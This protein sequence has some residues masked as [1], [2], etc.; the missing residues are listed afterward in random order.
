MSTTKRGPGRPRKTATEKMSA[1]LLVRM[2]EAEKAL[3]EG[4]ASGVGLSAAE[5]VRRAVAYC[6]A[7]K[8][9]LAHVE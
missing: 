1:T 8:V 7:C 3:L 6:A 5:Y 2:P 9:P 4:A